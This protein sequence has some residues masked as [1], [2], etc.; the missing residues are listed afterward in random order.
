M[1]WL[2]FLLICFLLEVVVKEVV[3]KSLELLGI[4]VDLGL[5]FILLVFISEYLWLMFLLKKYLLEIIMIGCGGGGIVGM[6]E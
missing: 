3:E 6:N 5:V 1:W 2:N 4:K